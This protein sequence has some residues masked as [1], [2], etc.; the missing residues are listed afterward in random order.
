MR[1]KRRRDT[2]AFSLA[3]LDVISC[4]FGAIVLLLVLSKIYEPT[5][6]EERR[7]DW[8]G[9]LSRLQQEIFELVGETKVVDRDLKSRREQLSVIEEKVARLESDLSSILA[10]HRTSREDSAVQNITNFIPE[11]S[12]KYPATSSDSASGASKGTR[13]FSATAQARNRIKA[14]KCQKMPQW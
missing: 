4:G 10:R 12:V 2:S 5:V 6:I 1:A 11:Y 7:D 3:F 14:G 8:N 13:L 9:V